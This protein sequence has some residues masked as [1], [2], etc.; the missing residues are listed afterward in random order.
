[1]SNTIPKLVIFILKILRAYSLLLFYIFYYL[2]KIFRKVDNW[3]LKE[4][5]EIKI[6][7]DLSELIK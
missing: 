7:N 1:M 2:Q 3:I 6:L 5:E 4:I